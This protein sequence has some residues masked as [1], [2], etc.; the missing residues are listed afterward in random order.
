MTN[1][2]NNNKILIGQTFYI[3]SVN[4]TINKRFNTNQSTW[5]IYESS[6]KIKGN[7]ILAKVIPK[8]YKWVAKSTINSETELFKKASDAGISPM[9]HGLISNIDY[10]II[11]M[12]KW[13]DGSLADLFKKNQSLRNNVSIKKSVLKLIDDI[14]AAGI[15]H[16][17]LHIHNILYKKTNN[18]IELKVIDFGNAKLLKNGNKLKKELLPCCCGK[19]NVSVPN[20]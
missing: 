8:R 15:V 14:H 18:K 12:E 9:Y 10:N 20:R 13:G 19:Y 2:N 1:C 17:D 7:N 3:N 6:S 5:Y 4:F 16:K 11:F